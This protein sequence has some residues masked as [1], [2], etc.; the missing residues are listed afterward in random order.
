MLAR[1]FRILLGII[2][3][4]PLA[5]II[6]SVEVRAGKDFVVLV[7]LNYLS[8]AIPSLVFSLIIEHILLGYR[9]GELK[10]LLIPPLWGVVWG[11]L[12]GMF[13]KISIWLWWFPLPS[14]AFV[15]A[16]IGG[17][18]ALLMSLIR[19]LTI[20]DWERAF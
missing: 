19:F 20:K 3:P 17:I 6:L 4:V 18:I 8:T 5:F 9:K 13:C 15:G 14:L 2:L 10:M 11:A 16:V 12:L 7:V 1:A